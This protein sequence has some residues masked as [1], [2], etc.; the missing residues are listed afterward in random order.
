MTGVLISSGPHLS[1]EASILNRS[2]T[3]NGGSRTRCAS[4][5]RCYGEISG[6]RC[7]ICAIPVASFLNQI[8]QSGS[9]GGLSGGFPVLSHRNRSCR[10]AT[11][12]GIGSGP[13]LIVVALVC[14]FWVLGHRCFG[15]AVASVGNHKVF[16][17][18]LWE[19]SRVAT[20]V[21]GSAGTGSQ[22]NGRCGRTGHRVG[23][24][25][26]FLCAGT[27]FISIGMRY[28]SSTSNGL[29]IRSNTNISRSK[30]VITTV[31]NRRKC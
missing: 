26:V 22:R 10:N 30:R 5:T 13:C 11:S 29:G 8:S 12:V 17:S 19:I 28:R 31:Y 9:D 20:Q 24:G 2:S 3:G 1:L 27:I 21:I 15:I 16:V 23:V 4:V 18:E 7:T 6:G 25:P 14:S